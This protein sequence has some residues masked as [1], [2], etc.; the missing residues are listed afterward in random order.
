VFFGNRNAPASTTSNVA[1]GASLNLTGA[2]Y[3]PTE[4]LDWNN[5]A[6]NSS[7]PCTELIANTIVLGGANL[8]INCPAGVTAIGATSSSLVE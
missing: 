4:T 8:Q 5:G 2:I 1:G 7:S 6:S 3:L